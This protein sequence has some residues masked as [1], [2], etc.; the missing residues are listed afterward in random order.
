MNMQ[1]KK[2]GIFFGCFSP[3]VMIATFAIEI[4]FAVYTFAKHRD[5]FWGKIIIL[6]LIALAIFQLAEYQVCGDV[7][8]LMWARVGY[9]AITL[10]PPLGITLSHII[11][12]K[13]LNTLLHKLSWVLALILIF[14]FGFMPVQQI[15]PV[16][17]GNYVIFKYKYLLINGFLYGAYYFGL[18][19]A[20]VFINYKW[21]KSANKLTKRLLYAFIIGYT[22][23]IVPTL[24]VNLA[25]PAT[26]YGIPSIMC[27][28]A[29]S[30]A[31][32]LTLYIR[33]NIAKRK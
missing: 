4:I 9:I 2:P 6:I 10:L 32:V 27:G 33:P 13:S 31:L 15:A 22:A 12:K 1:N 5:K 19:F 8:Q 28:F 29:V 3:A 30:W 11:A 21:A 24:V 16:C 14:I 25:D 23:F 26:I 18:L 7:D 17:G 20:N